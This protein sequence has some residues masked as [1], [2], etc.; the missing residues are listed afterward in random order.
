M[1]LLRNANTGSVVATRVDRATNFFDRAIGL[2]NRHALRPDEG[3]WIEPCNAIH[4]IGM[5]AH[6]D[7]I[8]L[9]RGRH[10][11]RT[12]RAVPPFRL[13]LACR[14]AATVIELGAGA[15]NA[16]DILPGDVLELV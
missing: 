7:V 4:T 12:H 15:L 5:R 1:A 2:L 16:H 9:D 14:K 3:L 11:L 8:F 13:A 10:V 6:L